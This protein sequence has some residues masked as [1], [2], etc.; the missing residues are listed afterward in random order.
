M[1]K[2]V[3][4]A[5]V[6]VALPNAAQAKINRSSVPEVQTAIMDAGT[7]QAGAAISRA[8]IL[9]EAAGGYFDPRRTDIRVESETRSRY[10]RRNSGD[11]RRQALGYIFG[12]PRPTDY[13]NEVRVEV[14][15]SNACLRS[16]PKD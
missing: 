5:L 13:R 11:P 1:K 8:K 2:I 6:L 15:V 10:D 4:L 12:T 16:K 3:L 9:C 7:E 14:N